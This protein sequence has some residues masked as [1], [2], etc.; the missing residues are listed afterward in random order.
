[1]AVA[2]RAGL[3]LRAR[4]HRDR[5]DPFL[6]ALGRRF[7]HLRPTIHVSRS[8]D[9]NE[10][11]RLDDESLLAGEI[12]D[13]LNRVLALLGEPQLPLTLQAAEATSPSEAEPMAEPLL[14]ATS[15]KSSR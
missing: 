9:W 11:E 6:H 14:A 7:A 12:H 1:V 2:A 3:R 5:L 8:W 15:A 10:A 4:P 13:A